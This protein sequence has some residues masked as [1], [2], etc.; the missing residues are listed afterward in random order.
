MDEFEK[1]DKIKEELMSLLQSFP[2]DLSKSVKD[3]LIAFFD[4]GKD[5]ELD[6]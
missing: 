6:D 3:N 4:W 1:Q 5:Y 2:L